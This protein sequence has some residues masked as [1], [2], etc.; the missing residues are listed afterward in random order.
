MQT[1]AYRMDKQGLTT[2][3]RE[4]YSIPCDHDEKEYE[5][6]YIY[7]YVYI[8]TYLYI[9]ELLFCIAEMNTTL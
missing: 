8:S 1:N 2:W 4:L 9:T 3:H 5:K 6:E 7:I